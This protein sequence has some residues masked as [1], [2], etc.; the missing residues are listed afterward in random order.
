MRCSTIRVTSKPTSCRYGETDATGA[1]GRPLCAGLPRRRRDRGR[2]LEL[3]IAFPSPLD[4]STFAPRH[5][6]TAGLRAR[7]TKLAGQRDGAL[8]SGDDAAVALCKD[9]V[10]RCEFFLDNVEAWHMAS[11]RD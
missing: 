5:D 2:P 11:S 9:H 7:V 3:P 8:T 1:T 4:H 10:I 6:P